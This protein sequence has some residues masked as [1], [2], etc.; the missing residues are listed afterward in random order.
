MAGAMLHPEGVVFHS[1][2]MPGYKF[3]VFYTKDIIAT[4]S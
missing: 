3:T 1:F 4:G 2:T